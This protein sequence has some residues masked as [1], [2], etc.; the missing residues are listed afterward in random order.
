MRWSKLPWAWILAMVHCTL[1]PIAVTIAVNRE[2]WPLFV[3]WL[4]SETGAAWA[5]GLF[6]VIAILSSA[7]IAIYVDQ[8][9][10][11]RLRD[12]RAAEEQAKYEAGRS[13]IVDAC[14]VARS[15]E[16]EFRAADGD[17]AAFHPKESLRWLRNAEDVVTYYIGQPHSSAALV[18]A[19]FATRR[20]FQPLKDGLTYY[21][22]SGGA[23]YHL[24]EALRVARQSLDGLL[25]ELDQGLL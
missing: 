15:I 6:S 5:Q 4:N 9:A 2:R 21:D 7:G 3:D 16:R 14:A 25:I 17:S 11:R 18:F 8:Q 19:L 20:H 12:D 13:A 23:Y 24:Q 22:G 1:F 10:A